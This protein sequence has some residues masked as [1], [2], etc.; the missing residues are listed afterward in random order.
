MEGSELAH[1]LGPVQSRTSRDLSSSL[2]YPRLPPCICTLRD[3]GC[4][5]SKLHQWQ[6]ATCTRPAVPDLF[7]VFFKDSHRFM[8][9]TNHSHLTL[10]IEQNAPY[11]SQS[12]P[13]LHI[14]WLVDHGLQPANECVARHSF[15][16]KQW[17]TQSLSVLLHADPR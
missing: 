12:F 13:L 14:G 17:T 9:Y 10:K 8:K 6:D 11:M 5:G 1:T 15:A 3:N 7:V 16:H 2:L 4:Q